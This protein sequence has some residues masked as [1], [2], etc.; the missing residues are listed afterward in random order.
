MR[1]EEA[2]GVMASPQFKEKLRCL[3]RL[4]L[5]RLP[6]LRAD[7]SLELLPEGYDPASRTLTVSGVTYPEDMSLNVAVET[8]NDLFGEFCFTDGERSKAVAVAALV[9]LY[10]AQLLPDSTL[11]PCFIVTKNA[12]GAGAG[13]L[14]SCAAVPVLGQFPTGVSSGEDDEMRKVLTAAVREGKLFILF[15]NQKARLSSAALEAFLSSPTWS[16]RL[17]G[18]NQTVNGPNI[19]TVF[20]TANGCTVSPD[21]RRRCLVVE[22]HLEAER[23]EDR[24]FDR[25]LDVPTLLAL[26][27]KILAAC[28]LFVRHWYTQ[29]QPSPSRSHSAF[30]AWAKIIGGIVQAVGFACPLNTADVA[31]AADEDGEA[32]RKLVEAMKPGASYTFA[33]IVELCRANE[34]FDGLVGEAEIDKS[35]RVALA[36]LIGRYDQRR[37]KDCRFV[38]KGKGHKRRYCVEKVGSDARSHARHAISVEAGENPIRGT[39][40]KSVPS[41]LSMHT[42]PP[43]ALPSDRKLRRGSAESAKSLSAMLGRVR[44]HARYRS[45]LR[46]SE[47]PRGPTSLAPGTVHAKSLCA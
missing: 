35:N 27:P 20:V 11:R 44:P 8:I 26:R 16:G 24:Q 29:G 18:V 25:P 5:C 40:G 34:C 14:V 46:K 28:W 23:A 19:A 13:T 32:M 9:G 10:A 12:E 47:C 45:S 37:V 38:I 21:M 22:L 30:P 15:D 36:R 42:N 3:V 4:N 1:E 33:E 17:L 2:R 41:V 43:N 7:G 39:E 31:V 6:I